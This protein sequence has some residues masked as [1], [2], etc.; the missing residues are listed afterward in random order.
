MTMSL[1][2]AWKIGCKWFVI[3]YYYRK[4]CKTKKIIIGNFN[5]LKIGHSYF[6]LK[7][8]SWLQNHQSRMLSHWPWWP[9]QQ[10]VNLL[11]GYYTPHDQEMR[12]LLN[13]TLARQF[14]GKKVTLLCKLCKLHTMRVSWNVDPTQCDQI[15]RFFGLWASFQSLWQQLICPNLPHS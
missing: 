5:A 11:H 3:Y 13:W 6:C 4:N 8:K 1:N 14:R 12:L 9:P 10:Q 7:D 15:G 2:L